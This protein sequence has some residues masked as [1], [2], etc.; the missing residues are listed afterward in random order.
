MAYSGDDTLCFRQVALSAS[1]ECPIGVNVCRIGQQSHAGTEGTRFKSVSE[2][3]LVISALVGF[4]SSMYDIHN[5]MVYGIDVT[6][7]DKPI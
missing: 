6:T 1:H 2:H 3:S 5:L 7:R 4:I